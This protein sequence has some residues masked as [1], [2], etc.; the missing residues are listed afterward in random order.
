MIAAIWIKI[1][2]YLGYIIYNMEMR[3]YESLDDDD[4]GHG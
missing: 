3:K 1:K 2:E 4:T